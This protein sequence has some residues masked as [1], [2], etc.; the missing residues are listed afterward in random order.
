VTGNGTGS[1]VRVTGNG[2]GGSALVTG[3]G[4]GSSINVTGNG[5]GAEAIT[6]TLPDGTG[7]AMEVEMGCTTATVTVLDSASQPVVT[8]NN[9]QVIGDT[10]LCSR[11]FDAGF[12]AD[13]GGDFRTK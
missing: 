6:I 10:G 9:V 11:G 13:P 3:N 1:S 4:T 7:M 5:T 2:T 8:F 12:R